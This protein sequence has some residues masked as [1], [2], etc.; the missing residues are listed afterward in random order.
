M[1]LLVTSKTPYRLFQYVLDEIS[2]GEIDRVLFTQGTGL[3]TFQDFYDIKSDEILALGGGE[4]IDVAKYIGALNR[5]NVKVIPTIVSTDA[6]FTSSTAYRSK[7][8]VKYMKTKKPDEVIIL[9]DVILS[10]EPRYNA[11]GWGDVV[12]IYTA[13]FEWKRF[14]DF[15]EKLARRAMNLLTNI[16]PII[17][18]KA[19]DKLLSSLREEVRLC[20]EYNKPMLEEG[21]EH[22]FAYCLERY[23]K[24]KAL[25]GELVGL[26]VYKIAQTQDQDI[27]YI[28]N[29]MDYAGLFWRPEQ[30]G[31]PEELI[32]KVMKRLPL[33]RRIYGYNKPIEL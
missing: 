18:S 11:A 9:K 1:K 17:D 25:H 16:V 14:P 3:E 21:S 23:L 27:E 5:C 10:A 20:E 24:R 30:L 28:S 29:L 22:F 8:Y 26:G 12:S 31:I 7:G 15:N 13:T 33:Y 2:D 6:M 4:A 32:T 19:L